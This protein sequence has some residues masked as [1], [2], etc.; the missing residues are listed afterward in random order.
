MAKL[1]TLK[2]KRDQTKVTACLKNIKDTAL[3]TTNLMP[4]VIEAVEQHC[5][6]G[7][8]ANVLRSVYGE[9]QS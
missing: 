8:I 1:S 5:T 6:L 3:S 4:S 9:Y 7:E 2:A